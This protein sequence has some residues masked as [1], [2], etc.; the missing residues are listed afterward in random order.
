MIIPFYNLWGMWNVYSRMAKY[1]MQFPKADAFSE[2][3]TGYIPFYYILFFI[4]SG[5]NRY[6]SRGTVNGESMEMVW[7]LSYTIDF[8]LTVFYILIV[9]NVTSA[10]N[11]LLGSRESEEVQTDEEIVTA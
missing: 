9:I 7:L 10:L 4:S 1:L 11:A 2:K 5:I 8:I 3:L 6:L